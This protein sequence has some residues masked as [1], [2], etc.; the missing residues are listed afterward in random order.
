MAT[1]PRSSNVEY[2]TFFFLISQQVLKSVPSH[3]W[4]SKIA[5]NISCDRKHI[6]SYV[7]H[8]IITWFGRIASSQYWKLCLLVLIL[9]ATLAWLLSP[10]SSTGATC[11]TYDSKSSGPMPEL[12]Y[13]LSSVW[14]SWRSWLLDVS[15]CFSLL[16]CHFLLDICPHLWAL[17]SS[18]CCQCI[19]LTFKRKKN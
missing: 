1:F 9:Q 17:L 11:G 2:V 5:L 4:T 14:P 8:F 19:Y 18:L 10:H 6:V 7:V 13:S 3:P 12:S 15:F 16:L